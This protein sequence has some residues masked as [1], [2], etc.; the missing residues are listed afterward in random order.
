MQRQSTGA[1]KSDTP[2]GSSSE[3]SQAYKFDPHAQI[4]TN[5]VYHAA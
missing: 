1:K 5:Y 4:H 2:H 3:M